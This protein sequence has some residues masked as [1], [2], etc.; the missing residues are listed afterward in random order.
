MSDDRLE[1]NRDNREKQNHSEAERR[2]RDQSIKTLWIDVEIN[3]IQDIVLLHL[4]HRRIHL[5]VVGCQ[6]RQRSD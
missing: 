4:I 5:S 3:G 1:D 6:E 2:K